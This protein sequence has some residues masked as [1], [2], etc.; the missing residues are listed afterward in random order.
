MG[1]NE[2]GAVKASDRCSKEGPISGLLHSRSSP[3][4]VLCSPR[5]PPCDF[6]DATLRC[7]VGGVFPRSAGATFLVPSLPFSSSLWLAA[8]DDAMSGLRTFSTCMGERGHDGKKL[9]VGR[10][11]GVVEERPKSAP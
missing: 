4:L 3:L 1:T 6:F 8:H 11:C 7:A 10:S 9:V 2:G 5:P